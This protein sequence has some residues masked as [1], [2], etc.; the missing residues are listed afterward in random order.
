MT[1][2]T[3]DNLKD[4]GWHI[5]EIGDNGPSTKKINRNRFEKWLSSE[6]FYS[7]RP[8]KVLFYDRV[9]CRYTLNGR[10]ITYMEEI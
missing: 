10:Q 1:I 8:G 6:E 9:L 4:A 2:I 5:K 3:E 7:T